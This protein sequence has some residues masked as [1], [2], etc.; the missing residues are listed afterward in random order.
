MLET[1]GTLKTAVTFDYESNASTYAIRVEA[2]DDYNATVEGNSTVALT[3][4]NEPPSI[5]SDGAGST[6]SLSV[7][8]NQTAVTTVS[9]IDP[10]S[11]T[12]LI[13]FDQR[14]SRPSEVSNC[15]RHGRPQFVELR[16]REPHGC[17]RRQR[18]RSHGSG[19][20]WGPL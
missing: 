6:A 11:G 16:L 20:R 5:S 9:G 15:F 14:R 7:A 3:N 10:D 1:N 18:I 12:T 17:G 2:K 4:V 19:E 8:E 13:F